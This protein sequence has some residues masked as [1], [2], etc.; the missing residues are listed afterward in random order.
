M[1]SLNLITI[2]IAI[3]LLSLADAL[4]ITG[5]QGGV[6]TATGQRPC[7]QE[8]STFKNSG[9]AFDLYILSLQRF[10]QQNQ[11]ALLSYYQVAG[12]VPPLVS[13]TWL[14]TN[15][16]GIHGR[17]FIAW[18]NVQGSFQAGYCTHSSI[19]FPSWH[20]PYMALFEVDFHPLPKYSTI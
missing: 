4:A 20:R 13:Y 12:E 10:Q 2:V 14:L 16:Q 5:P 17:P 18:D 6:N 19:L 9:P 8:F 7:R 3:C 15:Y 11:S 1:T